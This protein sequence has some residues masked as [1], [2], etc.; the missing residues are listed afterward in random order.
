MLKEFHVNFTRDVF[1]FVCHYKLAITSAF[2]SIELKSDVSV[3]RFN[4]SISYAFVKLF[5][6]HIHVLLSVGR[7]SIFLTLIEMLSFNTKFELKYS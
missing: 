2:S 6:P 4:V 3:K 1:V 7:W 5:V